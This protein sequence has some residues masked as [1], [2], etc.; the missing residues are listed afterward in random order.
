[1][2]PPEEDTDSRATVTITDLQRQI[3]QQ[4][5]IQQ[6]LQQQ[7]EQYQRPNTQ[8]NP[9]DNRDNNLPDHEISNI[10]Q[11]KLPLF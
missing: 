11:V 2:A 8:P 4:F 6:Q 9:N 10:K 3:N 7:F 5:T 1:M